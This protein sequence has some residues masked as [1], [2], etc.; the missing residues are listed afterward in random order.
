L[1]RSISGVKM[2]T[3]SRSFSSAKG[4]MGMG[5]KNQDKENPLAS[6]RERQ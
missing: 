2:P 1:K 5:K 4:L 3:L 6:L